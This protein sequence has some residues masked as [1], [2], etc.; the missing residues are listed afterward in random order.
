MRSRLSATR[1][2]RSL[3]AL[4]ETSTAVRNPSR[5]SET[6]V[7]WR[8]SWA[9]V[10][11][12]FRISPLVAVR[13]SAGRIVKYAMTPVQ[14]QTVTMTAR[15]RLPRKCIADKAHHRTDRFCEIGPIELEDGVVV[16]GDLRIIENEAGVAIDLCPI[17]RPVLTADN[18]QPTVDYNAFV[19]YGAYLSPPTRAVPGLRPLHRS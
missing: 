18:R 11:R 19:V 1:P 4:L 9:T 17:A 3:V 13:T 7:T 8:R 6:P 14:A 10:S 2:K 15:P 5:C 16:A 12:R